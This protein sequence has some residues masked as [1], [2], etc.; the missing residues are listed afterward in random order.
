[1]KNV[2]L[3]V[4]FIISFIV[5][6]CHIPKYTMENLEGEYS[7]VFGD[8]YS[9][10]TFP[11]IILYSDSS[12]EFIAPGIMGPYRS[13]GKW[14]ITKEGIKL[15]TCITCIGAKIEPIGRCD[16]IDSI[17][18]YFTFLLGFRPLKDIA[19]DNHLFILDS[20]NHLRTTATFLDE[21]ENIIVDNF[22]I[23]PLCPHFTISN[24]NQYAIMLVDNPYYPIIDNEVWIFKDGLLKRP[25]GDGFSTFKK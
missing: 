21:C 3:L 10:K 24:G 19:I 6:G 9:K 23:Y 15:S 2:F 1:M 12:F 22:E 8:D 14:G 5:V 18:V 11:L 7:T 25:I 13:T 16:E 20:A 4:C 17:D